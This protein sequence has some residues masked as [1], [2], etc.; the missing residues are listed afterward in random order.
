MW[1]VFSSGC[2]R[3][4]PFNP[5]LRWL[6]IRGGDLPPD[7]YRLL[8]LEPLE[9]DPDV[10]ATAADRQMAHV[11]KYQNGPHSALSQQLL[12]ELAT[13]KLCLLDPIRKASYDA[14][15]AIEQ[16][17]AAGSVDQSV[18]AVTVA[19]S[20]DRPA[21]RT[22]PRRRKQTLLL[23][24]VA[25]A[26]ILLIGAFVFQNIQ[27]PTTVKLSAPPAT[28]S[29][30]AIT[31]PPINA[32]TQKEPVVDEDTPATPPVKTMPAEA[33]EAPLTVDLEADPLPTNDP[34]NSKDPDSLPAESEGQDSSPELPEPIPRT[35]VLPP[36]PT[37]S[38]LEKT[39]SQF[40]DVY[41]T[42]I[43]EALAAAEPLALGKLSGDLYQRGLH[44][45][46]NPLAQYVLLSECLEL[47][48][49]SGN[50]AVADQAAS[51]ITQ[52]FDVDP[53]TVRLR[54][55]ER[56]AKT[57]GQLKK[58][59]SARASG[60]YCQVVMPMCEL[61][62]AR[63]D[64]EQAN[65]LLKLLSI[66][67]RRCRSTDSQHATNVESAR[68]TW[69]RRRRE[70]A[71]VQAAHT[72]LAELAGTSNGTSDAETRMQEA[73]WTIGRYHGLL[74]G[75]LQTAAP[76]LIQSNHAELSRLATLEQAATEPTS[77]A[78]DELFGLAKGWHNFAESGRRPGGKPLSNDAKR[79][80]LKRSQQ[81]LTKVIPLLDGF[82]SDEAK[83]LFAQ[84]KERLASLVAQG[85]IPEHA[86]I[87]DGRQSHALVSTFQYDGQRPLAIEAV[88]KP[89]GPTASFSVSGVVIGNANA[90]GG[91]SLSVESGY[92]TFRFATLADKK[93]SV[94]AKTR[95][96]PD[97]WSRV[98]AV[99]NGTML[100]I[101]KDSEPSVRVATNSRHQLASHPLTIGAAAD[102]SAV[103]KSLFRGE[104][105]TL[106]IYNELPQRRPFFELLAPNHTTGLTMTK[107]EIY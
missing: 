12:N 6:G 31:D 46:S 15:L 87:F 62:I 19:S 91:F 33:L 76:F 32:T 107:I 100:S 66:A 27:Q 63:D 9:S 45:Q 26:V 74:K 99:Y 67:S 40:D 55:A 94:R 54:S 84:S 72:L 65:A 22:S 77:L 105:A 106:R 14:T 69:K 36:I 7:H 85:P 39:R 73:F 83:Q 75:D 51:Q 28:P 53:V 49:Y 64:F 25:V 78:A 41:A 24:I 34:A 50:S 43:E 4:M 1:W 61:A 68:E 80:A 97:Q 95:L 48:I 5:Y 70:Y 86:F 35:I 47:A 44:T 11:R 16:S 93:L 8:G 30:E 58:Q 102:Q 23:A 90:N 18:A 13:A 60:R 56:V 52:H 88:V 57:I 10:I 79:T 29:R 92:W 82:E 89:S 59:R 38:E 98:L 101:Q 71:E 3:T 2:A 20:I 21:G 81:W 37:E 42:R 104:I 96:V 103:K 17:S